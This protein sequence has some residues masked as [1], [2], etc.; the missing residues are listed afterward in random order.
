LFKKRKNLKVFSKSIILY[1]QLKNQF[2]T[3]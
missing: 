1:F 2:G 3:F